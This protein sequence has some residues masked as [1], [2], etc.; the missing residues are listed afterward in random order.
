MIHQ[1]R[2]RNHV[3]DDVRGRMSERGFQTQDVRERIGNVRC[4]IAVSVDDM[5]L[6]H[7]LPR[8]YERPAA[9]A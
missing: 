5:K 9:F 8:D 7:P 1:A 4:D 2:I 3:L 6:R